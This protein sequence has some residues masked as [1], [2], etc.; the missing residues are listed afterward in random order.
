MKTGGVVPV[1]LLFF[2][3]KTPPMSLKGYTNKED[4]VHNHY[5]FISKIAEITEQ[6]KKEKYIES[7]EDKR[8][9][10]ILYAGERFIDFSPFYTALFE[11]YD[12]LWG[13]LIGAV[14]FAAVI[15]FPKIISLLSDLIL[16]YIFK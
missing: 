8:K 9:I 5:D 2:H 11:E 6:C 13:I 7:Y 3:I 12:K 16:N 10:R 14:G 15:N 4:F 1:I